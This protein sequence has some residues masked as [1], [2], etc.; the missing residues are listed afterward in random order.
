MG[1]AMGVGK[2]TLTKAFVH[3]VKQSVML[4]GDWCWEQGCDWN[5]TDQ[6]KKIV[7]DNICYLLN[8]FMRSDTINNIVLCWILH[9]PEVHKEIIERLQKQGNEFDVFDISLIC[10]DKTLQERILKRVNSN[11]EKSFKQNQGNNQYFE[12]AKS[13]MECLK[14]LDT[15]KIDV[16]GKTEQEVLNELIGIANR[17]K[18]LVFWDK[19]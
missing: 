7:L 15:I 9:L 2:T 13:R 5:Y 11:S 16:S 1:G 19:K 17:N 4:D 14:K 6:N 3:N 10:D 8:N 18:D 12:G